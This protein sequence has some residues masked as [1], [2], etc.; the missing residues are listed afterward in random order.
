MCGCVGV[1][2]YVDVCKSVCGCVILFALSLQHFGATSVNRP[3]IN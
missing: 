1:H 2:E 3:R